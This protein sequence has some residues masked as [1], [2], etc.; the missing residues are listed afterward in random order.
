MA[1]LQRWF[2][3]SQT[4]NRSVDSISEKLWICPPP[5]F[6]RNAQGARSSRRLESEFKKD[7]FKKSSF[8]VV[9][10]QCSAKFFYIWDHILRLEIR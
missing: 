5:I 8:F 3:F 9:L 7:Q 10:V 1:I 4:T 6:R 2:F